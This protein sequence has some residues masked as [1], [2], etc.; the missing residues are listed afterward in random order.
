[1]RMKK[2]LS[3]FLALVMVL[4]LVPATVFATEPQG[5]VVYISV[6]YDDKFKDDKNGDPIA[7][8]PVSFNELAS[9][10]LDAYGLSEYLYD[11]DE[12]GTPEITALH[13]II[14]AH[15]ELYG[16]DFSEVRFTGSPGSSYFE[17]SGIPVA[18]FVAPISM[19]H[20]RKNQ[21]RILL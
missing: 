8:V 20:Y 14:Y 16:G 21:I 17:A 2:L 4:S 1:M 12:D 3:L 18:C 10:D 15:E 19:R 5:D 7:F 9:V 11:E 13:L 6:S